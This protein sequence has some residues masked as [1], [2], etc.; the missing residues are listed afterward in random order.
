MNHKILLSESQLKQYTSV[1]ENLD[2]NFFRNQIWYCEWK[3][4]DPLLG[5]DLYQEIVLQHSANTLTSLN[6]TLYE[7]YIVP[8]LC[9]YVL[10]ES[11]DIIHNRIDNVGMHNRSDTNMTPADREDRES[12]KIQYRN[13]AALF[14]DKM[15][16]YL[17]Q[18]AD[19]YPL[20][21]NGNLTME[22]SKPSGGGTRSSFYLGKNRNCNSSCTC[23][24]CRN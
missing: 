6:Q 16:K 12:S 5:T 2:M 8:C 3:F 23:G 18:N 7:N 17:F 9:N 20:F 14:A 19:S 1:N 10:S 11:I 15:T 21:L 22:K 24:R 13:Q 4:I